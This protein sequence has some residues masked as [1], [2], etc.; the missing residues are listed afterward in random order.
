[1]EKPYIP[2]GYS[3]GFSIASGRTRLVSLLSPFPLKDRQRFRQHNLHGTGTWTVAEQSPPCS[4]QLPF[5]AHSSATAVCPAISC[6]CQALG[7]LQR[8]V[9]QKCEFLLQK[10]QR[11]ES[12]TLT[13]LQCLH[14]CYTTIWQQRLNAKIKHHQLFLPYARLENSD[15]FIIFDGKCWFIHNSCRNGLW[16][17]W[18]WCIQIRGGNSNCRH[19]LI[20]TQAVIIQLLQKMETSKAAMHVRQNHRQV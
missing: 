10:W 17:Q 12:H 18:G 15:E 3:E 6:V 4:R 14:F 1:M 11:L 5:P 20:S 7:M 8:T 16:Y 2:P 19:F 9:D 13:L